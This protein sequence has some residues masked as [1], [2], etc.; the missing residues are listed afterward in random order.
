MKLVL[1]TFNNYAIQTWEHKMFTARM[2]RNLW[3]GPVHVTNPRLSTLTDLEQRHAISGYMFNTLWNYDW[4]T[5]TT[6]CDYIQD[7]NRSSS[8]NIEHGYV[9]TQTFNQMPI[10]CRSFRVVYQMYFQFF[11]NLFSK[12]QKKKSSCQHRRQARFPG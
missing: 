4:H 5:D 10:A 9:E 7:L 12:R 3:M 8:R 11:L 1:S 6:S 2:G